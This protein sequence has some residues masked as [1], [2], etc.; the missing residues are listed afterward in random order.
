LEDIGKYIGIPYGFNMSNHGSADCSG[1]VMMF[2]REHGWTP[3]TYDLPTERQWYIKN[4]YLMERFL[5]KHWKRTKDINALTFG[6][7]VLMDINKESHAGI[8]LQYNRLLTTFPPGCKQW[9]GTELPS[10]S[11]IIK[12]QL[13]IPWFKSGFQRVT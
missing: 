13:W 9:D 3:D 7:V 5:L 10:R 12:K 6:D 11:M 1:L 8:V 2:Y 4:P